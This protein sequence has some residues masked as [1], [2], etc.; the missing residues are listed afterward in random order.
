MLRLS[1]RCSMKSSRTFRSMNI[2]QSA[3]LICG[4]WVDW[5]LPPSWACLPTT[6]SAASTP[7]REPRFTHDRQAP[8]ESAN[9]AEMI[10]MRFLMHSTL[11]PESSAMHRQPWPSAARMN[12]SYTE[13]VEDGTADSKTA[14][15]GER[16]S[17]LINIYGLVSS[18]M[19]TWES[20]G[21]GGIRPYQHPATHIA[22]RTDSFREACTDQQ[23]VQQ[24]S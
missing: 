14:T 18:N 12:S 24:I 9:T 23:R 10:L 5:L 17:T 21:A 19:A 16:E 13:C 3:T 15:T 20:G 2:H 4:I 22:W 6:M 11:P 1:S 8:Y 7:H